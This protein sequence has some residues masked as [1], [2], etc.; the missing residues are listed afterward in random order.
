LSINREKLAAFQLGARL[1]IATSEFETEF[2]QKPN[3]FLKI[4]ANKD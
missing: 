4:K 1:L 2:S 3:E